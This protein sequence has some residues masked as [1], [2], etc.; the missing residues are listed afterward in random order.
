MA[1]RIRRYQFHFLIAIIGILWFGVVNYLLQLS[2]QRGVYFDAE[3]YK[4]AA[5]LLY[6]HSSFHFYRPVLIAAFCGIPYLFGYSDAQVYAF[7]IYMN[8]ACWIGTSLL[9]FSLLKQFL[10]EKKAFYFTLLFFLMIG[11]ILSVFHLLT[12]S[13]YTL[14]MLGGFW[15]LSKYYRTKRFTFLSIGLAIFVSSMLIKPGSQYFAVVLVLYHTKTLI[16]NYGKPAVLF[17]CGSFLLIGLQLFGMKKQ[18]GDYTIS[19]ISGVTFYNYMGAKAIAFKQHKKL[20]QVQSVRM[21]YIFDLDFPQQKTV[22]FTDLK[23]QLQHNSVNLVKAYI[24][25]LAENAKTPSDC[26]AVCHNVRQD[27]HFESYKYLSGIITK[28]E[29]RFLTVC[30]FLIGIWFIFHYKR[31]AFYSLVGFYILYIGLLSGLSCFQGDRFHIVF[32]PMS[33]LLLAK[34][35]SDKKIIPSKS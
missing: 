1:F 27:V 22:G 16:Q 30:G 11:C 18:Y 3:N 4:D 17:L 32:F 15:F 20:K 7:G 31:D 25:N 28:W 10:S 21:P 23:D 34:F 14:A 12:E 19:Y 29:N 33:I 24:S 6:L 8:F 26:L 35:L 5:E 2:L 9:L 13:F